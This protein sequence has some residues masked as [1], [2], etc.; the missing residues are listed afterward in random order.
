MWQR[1]ILESAAT[2]L[3]DPDRY[4]HWWDGGPVRP[5]EDL[6]YGKLGAIRTR[7]PLGHLATQDLLCLV[8]SYAADPALRALDQQLPTWAPELRHRIRSAAA[9]ALHLP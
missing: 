1:R 4:D 2:L 5:H 7:G 6:A 3:L 8:L 9:V